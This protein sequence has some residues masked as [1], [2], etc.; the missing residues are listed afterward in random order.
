MHCMVQS[1]SHKESTDRMDEA[2]R[3]GEAYMQCS[4]ARLDEKIH[5]VKIHAAHAR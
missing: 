5:P 4:N 1:Q 3:A 2:R